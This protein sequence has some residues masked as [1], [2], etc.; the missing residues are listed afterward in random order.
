LEIFLDYVS[1]AAQQINDLTIKDNGSGGL[2]KMDD[3]GEQQETLVGSVNYETGLVT[4]FK[5]ALG[6]DVLPEGV[7]DYS[8]DFIAENSVDFERITTSTGLADSDLLQFDKYFYFTDKVGVEGPT[9]FFA[10]VK[11]PAPERVDLANSSNWRNDPTSWLESN[12]SL[13][14]DFGFYAAKDWIFLNDVGNKSSQPGPIVFNSEK[15]VLFADK[16][17]LLG[18]S[19]KSDRT[20]TVLDVSVQESA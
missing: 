19:V 4:L 12:E 6:G 13:A 14:V 7:V 18:E 16:I 8:V 11:D 9:K 10:D 5:D 3:L 2:W 1:N 17:S 15:V 20:R